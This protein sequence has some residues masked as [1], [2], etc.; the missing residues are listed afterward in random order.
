MIP[1]CR[2]ACA[3]FLNGSEDTHTEREQKPSF[4]YVNVGK[5]SLVMS[6]TT[7]ACEVH[8]KG[9]PMQGTVRSRETFWE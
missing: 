3:F 2:E 8:C 6:R 1:V 4:A 7:T 5:S 9:N